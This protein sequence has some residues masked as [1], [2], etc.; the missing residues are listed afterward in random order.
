MRETD[1]EFETLVAFLFG[2][3]SHGVSDTA[4]HGQDGRDQSFIYSLA[5]QDWDEDVSKAHSVADP[6]GELVLAHATSLNYFESS[7]NVPVLD[8]LAIYTE[9]GYEKGSIYWLRLTAS[10]LVGFSKLHVAGSGSR[11]NRAIFRR[12]AVWEVRH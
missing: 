9:L 10:T 2:A 4:W 5:Q 8:I 6:G 11:Q 7:W 12:E 1:R 3:V